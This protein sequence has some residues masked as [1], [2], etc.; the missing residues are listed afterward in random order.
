MHI[1]KTKM[2]LAMI[3]AGVVNQK[4]LAVKAGL[5]ENTVSSIARGASVQLATVG[6]I[7]AALGVDPAALVQEAPH[8]D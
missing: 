3:K 4:E 2:N 7:A 8:A 6:K 5:C 1:S